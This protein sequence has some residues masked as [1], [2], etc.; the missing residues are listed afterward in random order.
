MGEGGAVYTN[1][2]KLK[3]IAE[4]FRDWGRDCY[5][6]TG[7][8]NTCKKRFCWKFENLPEGYDHKYVYTHLGYNLKI[9]DLQAACGLAQLGKLKKFIK[10]R[11]KNFNYLLSKFKKLEEYFILPTYLREADP[12]WFGFALT[13]RENFKFNR[14]SLIQFL[15]EKKIDTRLLFAGNITKQPLMKNINF[16]IHE[17]LPNTNQVMNNTFW[18]GVYPGLSVP[19]LEY[20]YD[21]VSEFIYKNK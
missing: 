11:K 2:I 17:T 19:Q 9:T 20:V 16:K 21:K 7:F 10:I 1:N 14:N 4:S 6:K 15:N 3:M 13:L 5:C 12:S 18:I 8:S